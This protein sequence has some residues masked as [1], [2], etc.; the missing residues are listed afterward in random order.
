MEVTREERG[1][2][3]LFHNPCMEYIFSLFPTLSHFCHPNGNMNVSLAI[4]LH[5]CWQV[6]LWSLTCVY[7]ITL[8]WF[9]TNWQRI[10]SGL[11]H[12]WS[13][14]MGGD[15]G[16]LLAL[17]VDFR[18]G[19]GV[20][21]Q[22]WGTVPVKRPSGNLLYN[23]LRPV[24]RKEKKFKGQHYMRSKETPAM[25]LKQVAWN[26]IKQTGMNFHK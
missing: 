3:K 21:K 2:I 14:W 23:T 10:P 16:W 4:L 17:P 24:R 19:G 11:N 5:L 1:G 13:A 15:L 26:L 12:F 8:C 18:D 6:H 25:Q 20:G 9:T 22:D 7:D